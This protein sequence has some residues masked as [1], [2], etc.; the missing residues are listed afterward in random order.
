MPVFRHDGV[1]LRFDEVAGDGTPVVL[2]H[3]LSSART[4]WHRSEPQAERAPALLANYSPSW[5]RPFGNHLL[6]LDA[7]TLSAASPVE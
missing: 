4:T 6:D 2:L 1:D 5:I 7:A 3:G